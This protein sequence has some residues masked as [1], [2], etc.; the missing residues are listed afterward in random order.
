MFTIFNEDENKF[1]TVEEPDPSL[2]YTYADY[3]KWKFEE[4]IE[5]LRGRVFQL[6]A[7][8]TKHQEV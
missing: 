7:P 5:L 6:S 3:L 8:N 4:R 2:S 1:Q